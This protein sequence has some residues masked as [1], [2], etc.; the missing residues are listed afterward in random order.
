[1]VINHQELLESKVSGQIAQLAFS[2][3]IKDF[4]FDN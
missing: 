3:M 1:M 2:I 4:I